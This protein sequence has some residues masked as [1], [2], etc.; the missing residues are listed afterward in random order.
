[1]KT[2]GGVGVDT[3]EDAQPA[4]ST[5]EGDEDK[6]WRLATCGGD[7]NIRVSAWT[8]CGT[9]KIRAAGGDKWARWGRLEQGSQVADGFTG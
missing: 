5:K 6:M 1:M 8:E 9:S 3:S 7:K 2:S 4:N